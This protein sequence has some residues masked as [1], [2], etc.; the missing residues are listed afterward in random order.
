MGISVLFL[1]VLLDYLCYGATIVYQLKHW[2]EFKVCFE[3]SIGYYMILDEPVND[4][5]LVL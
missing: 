4:N 3:T 2:T 5:L 1:F